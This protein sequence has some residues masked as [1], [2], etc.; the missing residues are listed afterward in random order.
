MIAIVLLLSAVAFAIFLKFWYRAPSCFDNVKNGDETGIDCGGSCA[1]VCS[2]G[3]IKPIVR[4]DPRLF[5]IWPGIWNLLVYV[6]NPN[7]NVDATYVPYDL[8]FYDETNTLLEERKGATILPKNKTVGVFEGSISFKNGEKP[9]RV[10]FDLGNDIVWKKNEDREEKIDITNSPILNLNSE[11]KVLATVK[12][13][14][15][16]D[17][18]NIELVVAIFDGQDNALAASRTFVETLKKNE[19]SNVFFTWPRP[20]ELGSK[21]CEKPSDVVLL[22]DR[23]GSMSSLGV[24]PPEPLSS[25]K[26]AALSFI[27]NLKSKDKV[28]V[29]SFATK[30]KDPIDLTL[31]SDFDS[32]KQAVESIS[33]EP[34]STQYTNIYEALHSAWQELVSA[35]AEDENSKIIVLLTDGQA[36]NPKNPAGGTE[37]EDIKYAENLAAAEATKAKEDGVAI[38]TI[39]LGKAINETFLKNTASQK[40]N[41]F[42]APTAL[43]LE[44]I[45]KNISTKICK[46]IPARIEITYKIYGPAL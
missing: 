9:K 1:L 28:G 41:Y 3:A 42:F 33:I 44:N 37:E 25:A 11:P 8:A 29:V 34:G 45:Y 7:T 30:S 17:L 24:N 39:G 46:E 35:R 4:W 27:E 19:E 14:S 23:S 38:Y 12:N 18:K 26:Q 31:T 43:D 21:A 15:T 22:M 6:E 20:F 16:E 13:N 36:T 10:I 5:E 32:A 2:D 40:D